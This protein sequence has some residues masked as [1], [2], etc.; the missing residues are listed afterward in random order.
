MATKIQITLIKSVIHQKP[1]MRATVRS[2]GLRKISST[3][4][5]DLNPAVMGMVNTVRHLV[6]WK[7]ID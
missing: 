2:L 5:K 1:Q 4:V 3:T 7:E 6:S